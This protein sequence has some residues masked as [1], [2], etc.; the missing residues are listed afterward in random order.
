M[1][2]CAHCHLHRVASATRRYCYAGDSTRHHARRCKAATPIVGGR[3]GE[4][5][6]RRTGADLAFAGRRTLLKW[7]DEINL[8]VVR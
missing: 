1:W 6:A 4:P 5:L 7:S 2:V 3:S 8:A